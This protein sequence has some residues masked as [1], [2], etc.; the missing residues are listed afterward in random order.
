[1]MRAG[2]PATIAHGG[3][4]DPHLALDDDFLTMGGQWAQD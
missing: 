3:N 2:L 1:M 4:T